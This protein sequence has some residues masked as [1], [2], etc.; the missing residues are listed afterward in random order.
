MKKKTKFHVLGTEWTCIR[1]TLEEEPSYKDCD[2]WCD[3]SVKEIHVRVYTDE[4]KKTDDFAYANREEI[5]KRVIVH[6][7]I[8]AYFFESGLWRN[9][10]SVE[11]PWAMNEECV[12]WLAIQFPKIVESCSELDAI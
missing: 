8:H 2:G 11:G 6:E 7:V 1:E 4:E 3:P 10:L 5:D 9:S 12:D